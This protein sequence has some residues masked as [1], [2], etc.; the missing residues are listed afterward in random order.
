MSQDKN[1]PKLKLEEAIIKFPN[2]AGVKK[3]WNDEGRRNFCTLIPPDIADQLREEGWN[4]KMLKPREE[5]DPELPYIQVKVNFKSSFAPPV[6]KMIKGKNEVQITEDNANILD[7]ADIEF[8]DMII[9]PS[10]YP[11]KTPGG[12]CISPYLKAM[13]VYVA[14]DELENRYSDCGHV[15][16][17]DCNNCPQAYD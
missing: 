14:E 16:D 1:R 9:N 2:F 12:P 11:P 5:G 8:A 17:G 15:C 7:Y 10:Y 13:N 4:V 3:E 6:I